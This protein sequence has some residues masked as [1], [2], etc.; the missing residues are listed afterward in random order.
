MA[1]IAQGINKL[2]VFK[3]QTGIGAPAAGSGGQIMRREKSEFKLDRDTFTNNEIVQHQQSTGVVAG[4]RKVSGSMSGVVSPNTYST[5]I[6]S[7]LRKA[8]TATTA[9][10]A[11]T[12]TIS[13]TAALYTFTASVATP[14]FLTNGLKIF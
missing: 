8:F 3:K 11:S 12:V 9:F 2:T 5:I 10:A 14:N 7:L 6:A 4:L 1:T 13:G